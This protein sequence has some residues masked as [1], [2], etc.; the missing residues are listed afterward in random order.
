MAQIKK[1]ESNFELLRIFAMFLIV[2]HHLCQHGIYLAPN[3]PITFNTIIGKGFFV[4][5]GNLGN[6]LFIL[7]SG[8]F[9]SNSTFSWKRVV[10]LW[11][12]IFSTSVIIGLVF[13]F[14]NLPLVSADVNLYGFYNTMET[15]GLTEKVFSLRNLIRASLP[16]LFGNNWFASAYLLFYLFT[17]F[18]N[19]SLK[20]LDEKKHRYLIILM[21]VVGTIIYMIPGQGIFQSNNLFYFILGYYIANYIRLYN[22][23]FLQNQKMNILFAIILSALF[24]IWIALVLKYR[25]SISFI[26]S[27]FVQ[28][29]CYPFALNR[30]PALLNALFVFA[31]F[32]NLR[33]PYNRFINLI[34]STTFGIYLI[35]ENPYFNKFLWH[36]IFKMDSFID[37]KIL[38]PYMLFAVVI[39][40][41]CCAMVDLLRKRFVEKPFLKLVDKISLSVKSKV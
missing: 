38:L 8:Y 25:N 6:Y 31:F 14:F 29:F 28:V 39:T 27:H 21:M 10:K 16:T 40:F 36:K 15:V 30:F 7:A 13:Y 19:E 20:V 9:V 4:W 23:K 17:P 35:H 12:Q 22:P 41:V 24:V 3:A 11:F 33:V 18:L 2:W 1:R 37:S 5:T 26:N 34:A 32:R